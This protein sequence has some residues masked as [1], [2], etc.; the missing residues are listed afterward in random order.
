M[1]FNNRNAQELYYYLFWLYLGASVFCS[2]MTII[3]LVIYYLTGF[4]ESVNLFNLFFVLVLFLGAIFFRVNAMH[5][6]RILIENENRGESIDESMK[7]FANLHFFSF[8]KEKFQAF[9]QKIRDSRSG[10]KKEVKKK[11]KRGEQF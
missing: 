2:L 9:T 8:I 4:S 7:L 3:L 1:R 10:K 11:K 6:H 5:Y